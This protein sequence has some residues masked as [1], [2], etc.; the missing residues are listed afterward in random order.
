MQAEHA[1]SEYRKTAVHADAT[2]WRITLDDPATGNLID[3]QMLDELLHA[4][5]RAR[6][7]RRVRALVFS[8]S[9]PDF[10]L[11]GSRDELTQPTPGNDPGFDQ[12]RIGDKARRLCDAIAS[13]PAVTIARI[14]GR[15]HGAGFALALHCDL[16]VGTPDA[17]FRL[18]ELAFGLPAAWGG[19][20]ARLVGEI[21]AARTREL[22]LTGQAVDA[23]TAER[24][25]VLHRVVSE[26]T[27][28][29]AVERWVRPIV[30]C[31]PHALY[32]TKAMLGAYSAANRLA[33]MGLLDAALLTTSLKDRRD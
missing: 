30:R 16:R 11:G 33:D 12:R 32:T 17:V 14:H 15:A 8:G 6:A 27:L 26:E 23:V 10:C 2:T 7:E 20:M 22:L 31:S 25:S 9:G 19:A 5:D 3:E 28:D 4:L 13:H 1:L 18:P 21:G 29:K 24:L